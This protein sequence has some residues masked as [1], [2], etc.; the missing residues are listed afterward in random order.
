MKLGPARNLRQVT[1]STL[2]DLI[3]RIEVCRP[4]S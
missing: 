4:E 1:D 2:A 3:E